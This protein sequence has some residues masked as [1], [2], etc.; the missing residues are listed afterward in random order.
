MEIDKK[1]L[2]SKNG[3]R[4]HIKFVLIFYILGFGIVYAIYWI[5]PKYYRAC[6]SI[7]QPPDRETSEDFLSQPRTNTELFFSILTSRTIKDEII[8]N[9]GLIKA[10]N[11]RTI[12][13]ARE[14]LDERITIHLTKEKVI[15]INV[16]DVK[17]ERA[18]EIAN[19]FVERLDNT[20]KVLS[21]T[22]AKQDRIFTEK[23]LNETENAIKSEEQKIIYKKYKNEFSQ[24][25]KFIDNLKKSI[26]S[27][28]NEYK[29]II[30]K[31]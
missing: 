20:V 16:I 10:Y 5:S 8:G 12:D 22:T 25:K 3:F 18:A 11:V 14:E 9:F 31:K 28:Y 6:A 13:R 17:P 15:E 7:L 19:F 26:L 29:R 4:S 1:K 24:T 21:I 30:N 2:E 27:I 23:Q